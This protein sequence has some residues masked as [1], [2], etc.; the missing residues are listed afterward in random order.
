MCW[1]WK[2]PIVLMWSLPLDGLT[3]S[4]FGLAF[5]GAFALTA[6]RGHGVLGLLVGTFAAFDWDLFR[7]AGDGRLFFSVVVFTSAFLVDFALDLATRY[8]FSLGP[9]DAPPSPRG[10]VADTAG[11]SVFAFASL[12][13]PEVPLP[14]VCTNSVYCC[15]QILLDERGQL[16]RT[17][18]VVCCFVLPGSLQ[19]RASSFFQI[20]HSVAV[21]AGST[22]SIRT[23][24]YTRQKQ[25]NHENYSCGREDMPPV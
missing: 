2:G 9:V 12:Q 11:F 7:L 20:R 1:L 6:V 15:L 17:N 3:Y 18:H 5:F 22:L 4:F 24:N 25:S 23:A 13:D 16:F 10:G 8:F 14:F 19:R 21:G